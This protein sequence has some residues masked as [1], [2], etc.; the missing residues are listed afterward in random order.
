VLAQIGRPKEPK[1]NPVVAYKKSKKCRGCNELGHNLKTC[2][3]VHLD[4]L[5]DNLSRPRR[6]RV[7]MADGCDEDC[8]SSSSDDDGDEPDVD[9]PNDDEDQPPRKR[10][11]SHTLNVIA[12][13]A[14][15]DGGARKMRSGK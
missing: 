11:A 3:N 4:L 7:A 9:A 5:Y 10:S 8:I 15:V 2:V 12:E 13:H 14:S 6:R 1:R